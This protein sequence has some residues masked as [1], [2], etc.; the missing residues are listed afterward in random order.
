MT[1]NF[2][3]PNYVEVFQERA[4]K[5]AWIREKPDERV[6]LLQAYY[7]DHIPDFISD[8]GMTFDPRNVEVDRPATI[9]FI[10][11]AKQVEF[12]D[13]LTWHWRN[14]KPLIG[15]KSREVGLSWLCVAFGASL[16]L[17]YDGVIIG[18]GSRKEEYVDKANKPKSIFWKA[19]TFVR[20]IPTEFRPGWDE[21]KHAP[22]MQIRF[23]HTGSSMEGEAGDNIGR[24]DRTSIYFVDESAFLENPISVDSALSQTTNCRVDIS[25]ANGMANPFAQKRHNGKIPVFTLHWRDD[26]RKDQA[27]YDKQCEDL[28]NPVIIAQELDINYNASTEGVVIPSAWV[29]A[30]IDA[31]VKLGI[32]VT[33]E[34]QGAFDVA[35]EGKDKLAFASAKGVLV[36]FIDEWSGKDGDVFQSTQRVFGHCDELDLRAF[37]YDADGLGAGVRGD[38]RVINEQRAD[39]KRLGPISAI[40]FRG[41]GPVY[42]PESED[43]KGRKNQDYFMN[44]KA[45]AWNALRSRFRATYRAVVEGME[46]DPSQIISLSSAMPLLTKLTGELSQPTWSPNTIGKMVVDKAPDDTK[47]PNLADAVMML[48]STY[49][50]PLRISLAALEAV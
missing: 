22:H 12:L 7:R 17:F 31:H 23:P 41:S 19:R 20:M 39:G 29:Q 6:P 11:F 32:Q 42:R 8:W 14:R 35:D 5:L 9:P 21:R 2:R 4:Q 44:Y 26:P 46:Y 50:A 30:A 37:R 16:C 45:Q 28:D 38:A 25:S 10:P 47:S 49:R 48:F 43:V 18:Y 24:G 33:G 40:A 15:E 34:R 13:L 3:D 36:D 1:F 27:W